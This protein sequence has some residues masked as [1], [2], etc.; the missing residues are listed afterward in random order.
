MPSVYSHR[1]LVHHEPDMDTGSGVRC[2]CRRR[3]E[4]CIFCWQ[5]R[6]VFK[7]KSHVFF[8]R[9]DSV[10]RLNGFW[11]SI[12]HVSGSN[13]LVPGLLM[14]YVSQILNVFLVDLSAEPVSSYDL[15]L[16]VLCVLFFCAHA[17]CLNL[18]HL[19]LTLD[20]AYNA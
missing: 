9:N 11:S 17:R 4:L 18:N 19:M 8:P 10:E 16:N 7:T 1:L 2:R 5:R 15:N 20:V 14:Y 3:Q 6:I 12:F 13:L